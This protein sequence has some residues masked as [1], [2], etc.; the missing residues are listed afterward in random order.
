MDQMRTVMVEIKENMRRTNPVED[1]VHRTDSPFTASINGHPLPP[2]FKMPSLDSY[3]GARD[4]FDHIATFKTIIHLQ[5]VP[6]KIMCRAFPT[7]FKGPAR[8]WFSKTPPNSVSSFEELSKLFV[9]NFIGGQRHKHSSSSLLTIEQG[10]NESLGSFITRFNREALAI[11]E[12]DDKLLLVAFH[13]GVNSNLFIHKLYEKEPQSMAEL[14]HLAQNFMNAEDAIIAKKKKRAERMEVNPM[15]HSK[16]GPR[17]KN[18]RTEDKKD[19]DRDNSKASPSVRNQKYTPLNALLDQVLV[20]IKDDPSLKWLENMKGDPN[21]RNK[22]KYCHFYRDHGH[23]TDECFDLKQQIENLIRQGNLR[24][25]VGR[26]HKD[27]KLKRK[28]EESSRPP[29]G[30]I[31]VIIGGTSEVQSSQSKKTYLKVVQNVQHFGRSPRTRETDEP[32]ISFT[33]EEAEG[34]HHPRDDAIVI[35]LLIAYYR[36]KRV[37][38]DN[39]SSADILYCPTFQQ[40]R[41]RRDQ[42]H[43]ASSPLIGFGGM[44]VQ[45]VGT[46]IL[47]VMVGSYP[48]QI[49]KEV[50][51][52][53]VDCSF[54]YNA[55]IGRPTLNSSKAIGKLQGDQLAARE[56]YLAILAVDEQ[57]QT[58]SIEERRIVVEPTEVLE[59]VLLQEN[60]PEKFTRIGIGMKEKVKE[61]LVQ[62]LRKNTDVF[63]WS[64]DD[65]P[66]I[67]PMVITHRLNV[68]PSS[69][70]VR[71]K[72][73]VFTPERDKAIKEEGQKLTTAHLIREVY[74]PDWLVNVVM[75]K[76]ANGK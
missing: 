57:K 66:G 7:T 27:E 11:D 37:L 5:E 76:K 29:L 42:H 58:M 30:E 51:F 55:I 40:M 50:N 16:E 1:L 23:D 59:D 69:K 12:V 61:D 10:E 72:K 3:D 45:P 22:N 4:L 13:N 14:I 38:V 34:I 35:T 17:P 68:F 8:V 49:T 18:G 26:D 73:R 36:T 60:N 20:Q 33:N 56:C 31:R 71:Q 52:L 9:N 32:T 67:D 28:I 54:S 48:Q 47:P 19:R 6:D 2:K 21:K 44:K 24:H 75:V 63:A 25:F 46:I 64:H 39:G 62:F 65:M 41:L 70:L 74:Y 43:P 53:V 15:L